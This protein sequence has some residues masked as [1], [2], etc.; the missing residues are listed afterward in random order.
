MKPDPE[1]SIFLIDKPEGMSSFQTAKATARCFGLKKSGHS[2][3]LDMNVTGVLVVAVGEATKAI[4]QL[5]GLDKSYEGTM[6]LQNRINERVFRAACKQF[7]GRIVQ[8]PPK[9]CAVKRAP[10]L[11]SIYSLDI[12][13]FGE[14][15]VAFRAKVESGTYIRALIRDIGMMLGCH[16][17]MSSLRR[18]AVGPFTIDKC[19]TL[20]DLSEAN[21]INV[22]DALETAGL[23]KMVLLD[24]EIPEV[25]LGKIIER[26]DVASHTIKILVDAD[27]R[28]VA[29]GRVT[30]VGVHPF[31]VFRE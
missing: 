13:S 8:L 9:K 27:G 19:V 2:G 6:R 20:E 14:N 17:E 18:T 5:V 29:L 31:R 1:Y 23:E 11:R 16:I 15:E 7:A 21:A 10:R 3:T 12:T 26:A 24:K 4:S 28:I 25:R 30:D 22:A